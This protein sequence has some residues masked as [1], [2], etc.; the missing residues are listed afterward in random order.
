MYAPVGKNEIAGMITIKKNGET[1]KEIPLVFG[2]SVALDN[3]IPLTLSE[4]LKGFIFRRN[5]P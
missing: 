1:I 4:K 5:K 2:D 3:T